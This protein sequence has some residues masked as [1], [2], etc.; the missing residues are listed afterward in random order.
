MAAAAPQRAKK[1][2]AHPC[3]TRM[4]CPEPAWLFGQTLSK[5]S[6]GLALGELEVRSRA[7]DCAYGVG[8]YLCFPAFAIWE[9]TRH[10]RSF[11]PS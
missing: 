9:Q 3:E 4:P 5:S 2:F 6:S 10:N 11:S 7:E 1:P 8:R